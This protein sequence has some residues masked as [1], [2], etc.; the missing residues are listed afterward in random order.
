MTPTYIQPGV[1][2]AWLRACQAMVA[3]GAITFA[4]ALAMGQTQ[5]AWQA[6]L[7]N[8]LFWTGIAQCGVI[9]SA[10]Y[11]ITKGQWCDALRRMGES[12]A[13]F[14][15]VAVGLFLVLMVFGASVFPWSRQPYP[16]RENWL[17]GSPRLTMRISGARARAKTR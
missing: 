2:R 7:L 10:A 5:R 3:A 12:M 4:V 17:K 11:R 9:F 8:F 14:L 6:Y 13:F 1:P 15:P 16:G